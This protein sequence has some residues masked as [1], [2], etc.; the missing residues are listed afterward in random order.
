[1][2]E[3]NTGE[4]PVIDLNPE[5]EYINDPFSSDEVDKMIRKIKNGKAC[6]PDGIYPEFI[7]YAPKEAV[8]VFTDMFNLV[9][10]T[11]NVPDALKSAIITPIHKKGSHSDPNNYRGISLISCLGKLFTALINDRLSNFLEGTGT[12]GNEQAGFRRGSS[13]TDHILLLH[14][15]ISLDINNGKRLYCAFI[16]YEK[17]FDTINRSK[18]WQKVLSSGTNG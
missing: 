17:A 9:L 5:N 7:K 6:G 15:L 1:M 16:D 4:T 3:V 11:G 8:E 13:T 12:L 10:K 18:L 14:A 2:N